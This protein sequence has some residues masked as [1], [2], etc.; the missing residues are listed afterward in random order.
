MSFIHPIHTCSHIPMCKKAWVWLRVLPSLLDSLMFPGSLLVGL[1]QMFFC[2]SDP[3]SH[4]SPPE[5]RWRPQLHLHRE[6]DWE[7][8][9]LLD[10]NRAFVCFQYLKEACVWLSCANMK[11]WKKMCFSLLYIGGI[12]VRMERDY[13]TAGGWISYISPIPLQSYRL[14]FPAEEMP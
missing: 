8:S 2:K 1:V 13:F 14:W 9:P 11:G 3:R 7:L 5:P 6:D 4:G 12:F 10:T